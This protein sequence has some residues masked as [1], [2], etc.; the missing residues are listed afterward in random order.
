MVWRVE[1][2]GEANLDACAQLLSGKL[3]YPSEVV[4]ALPGIWR[5]LLR[6]GAIEATVVHRSGGGQAP[7]VAGFAAGV[8]ISDA[9]AAEARAAT[10]PYLT[11]R[12]LEAELGPGRSP[13]LRGRPPTGDGLTVLNLHYAEAPGLSQED[14]NGLRFRLMKAFIEAFRG[15]PIEEALQEFWDEIPAEFV[16][17]GWGYVRNDYATWHAAHPTPPG[18]RRPYLIGLSRAEARANPGNIGAPLFFS[19]TARFRYTPAQKRLLREAV[20]GGTD[21][22]LAA[23]LALSVP[24]VKSHWRAIHERTARVD[25]E[26]VDGAGLDPRPGAR[27]PEKRRRLLDYLREHPEE[28]SGA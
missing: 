23:G 5:R 27:G 11:R 21:V 28:I 2:L 19:P 1:P 25:P 8:F 6:D 12:T 16:L 17:N 18:G 24:T 22:E 15:F 4:A 9:W 3:A 10:E 13:I 26:L 20:H 7:D 14:A